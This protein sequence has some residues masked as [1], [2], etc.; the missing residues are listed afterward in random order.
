MQ[1]LVLAFE[2]DQ[3]DLS[4]G[5]MAVT[6]KGPITLGLQLLLP[7]VELIAIDAQLAV[8]ISRWLAAF[9]Q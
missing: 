9:F 4:R 3:F 6:G 1:P 5:R 2:P 7:F 8:Q